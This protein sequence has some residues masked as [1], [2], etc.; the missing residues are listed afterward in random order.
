GIS[1][2]NRLAPIEAA[3]CRIIPVKTARFRAERA[4]R[5][6]ALHGGFITPMNEQ[7]SSF[8]YVSRVLISGAV[9]RRWQRPVCSPRACPISLPCA[10]RFFRYATHGCSWKAS[11]VRFRVREASVFAPSTENLAEQTPAFGF[12]HRC[13]RLLHLLRLLSLAFLQALLQGLRHRRIGKVEEILLV[14]DAEFH[15]LFG[16]L[17]GLSCKQGPCR[18]RSDFDI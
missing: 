4:R 2:S 9:H 8:I 13:N 16:L 14:D 6:I 12:G 3:C 1:W 18:M 11:C 15:Q 5:S 10:H 17:L 7:V